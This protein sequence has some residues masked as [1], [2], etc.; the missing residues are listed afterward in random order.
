MQFKRRTNKKHTKHTQSASNLTCSTNTGI[1]LKNLTLHDVRR[2]DGE[3]FLVFYLVYDSMLQ[4][5]CLSV[6]GRP[7]VNSTHRPHFCSCD[8]DLDLVPMTL[9]YELDPK[10][11][12]IKNERSRSRL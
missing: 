3:S 8:L 10:I 5:D 11:T 2:P 4:Q 7:R 6:E 12:H 1:M 9:M